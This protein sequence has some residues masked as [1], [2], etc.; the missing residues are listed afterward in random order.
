MGA[1]LLERPGGGDGESGGV[2]RSAP[3]PSSAD[4]AQALPRS[5][6]LAG[7]LAPRFY[8]RHRD[9]A[10]IRARAL[11]GARSRRYRRYGNDRAR[12][13]REPRCALSGDVI[14]IHYRRNLARTR[15]FRRS[16]FYR[17]YADEGDRRP[18]WSR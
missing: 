5:W 11:R 2:D 8:R 10:G 6:K 9:V 16:Y 4:I 15:R 12:L 17:R 7:G 13:Q 14:T 1:K 3:A 18:F